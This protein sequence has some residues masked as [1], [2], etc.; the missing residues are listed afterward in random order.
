MFKNMNKKTLA[1]FLILAFSGELVFYVL[2]SK[3]T[4]YDAFIQALNISNEQ[5][6]LLST[7]NGWI[8]V[9]GYLLGGILADKVSP[10][11]MMS[12]TF[13]GTGICNFV[14]GFFPSYPVLMVLFILMGITTSFTYWAALQKATRAIGRRIGSESKAFGFL[15]TGRDLFG[16]FV[17]WVAVIVFNQYASVVFGLRFVIWWFAAWLVIFGIVS[18]FVFDKKPDPEAITDKDFFR[19]LWLCVKNPDVWLVTLMAFGGY[20]IGS[21]YQSY[22]SAMGTS[23]FGMSIGSGAYFGSVARY[24]VLFGAFITA[25]IGQRVGPSKVIY[26][27]NYLQMLCCVGALL[28]FRYPNLYLYIAVVFIECALIGSFRSH[29]FA[30]VREAKLPMHMTGTVFGFMSL[31]IY[32]SDAW[33]YTVVG[34]W[35]DNYDSVTAYSK[36]MYMILAFGVITVVASIIFRIRNRKNIVEV[37]EEEKQKRAE[38]EAAKA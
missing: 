19:Q 35:L 38:L 37:L 4:Y 28:L 15:Q 17:I 3:S 1:Q 20:A 14:Y 32:T 27:N 34:R 30:T 2:F 16:A 31:I 10:R 26:Y 7:V 12:V 18:L 13:L 11:I 6:G 21:L 22:I 25:Y 36:M 23:I 29:K 5:F 33:P 9:V 8:A 24:F